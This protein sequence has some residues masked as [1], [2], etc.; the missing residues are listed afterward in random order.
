MSNGLLP[1]ATSP[2]PPID[3]ST[4][5]TYPSHKGTENRMGS[6]TEFFRAYLDE[7]EESATRTYVVGGFVGKA[8]VWVKLESE[9]LACLPTGM[10]LFHTTDCF[11][12]K[13]QFEG[14]DIPARVSLLDRL[15]DVILAHEI[16]LIGYGIDASKY[17]SLAPKQKENEF[18][19]NKYAAPFGGA[20]QLAC[21]CMGNT[22]SPDDI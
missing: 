7:S 12:G 10:K 5:E 1:S 17:A 6:K 8:D 14:L 16:R 20:V 21:E 3:K 9:W 22:P 2:F 19:G 13:K 15:T 18:L 11:A 4:E